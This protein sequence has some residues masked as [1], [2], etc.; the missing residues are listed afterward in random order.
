MGILW[1]GAGGKLLRR[2]GGLT[3]QILG[4]D[5]DNAPIDLG[6]QPMARNLTPSERTVLNRAAAHALHAQ[7]VDP[8]AHT[9]PA[10]EGFLS[11]FERQVDPDGT[12]PPDERARRA[13]HAMRSHMSMLSARSAIKRRGSKNH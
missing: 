5:C 8:V 7:V 10:R 3:S 4:D 2:V 9:A 12:L 6:D 13:D 1:P 11:R